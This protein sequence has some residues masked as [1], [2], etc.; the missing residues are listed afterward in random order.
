MIIARWAKDGRTVEVV[1]TPPSHFVAWEIERARFAVEDKN[2][3]CYFDTA[4]EVE[5]A[6]FE[7]GWVKA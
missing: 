5:D 1:E 3:R 2:G 4:A 7:D 6:L